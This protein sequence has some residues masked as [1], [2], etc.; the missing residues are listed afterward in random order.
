MPPTEAQ[1]ALPWGTADKENEEAQKA[2]GLSFEESIRKVVLAAA[3][4]LHDRGDV[5]PVKRA[6]TSPDGASNGEQQGA[7]LASSLVDPIV[8]QMGQA[9]PVDLAEQQRIEVKWQLNREN[10]EEAKW[11]GAT[12]VKAIEPA[13]AASDALRAAEQSTASD[14]VKPA[15]LWVMRYDAFE[16]FDEEEK[17]VAFITNHVLAH[18]D[19]VDEIMAWRNEGDEY[20]P[21]ELSDDSEDESESSR[22]VTTGADGSKTTAAELRHYGGSV[23]SAAMERMASVPAAAQ[24]HITEKLCEY[25]N[26]LAVTLKQL[27]ED[28]GT[29]GISGDDMREA[30]ARMK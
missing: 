23:E 28:K 24:Q 20:E 6:R 30:L 9:E 19:D 14:E 5:G 15:A 26:K 2:P 27:M 12:L 22:V 21:S 8:Y 16:G 25:S 11:W 29:G 4:D 17:E 1:P 7:A 13:A 10:S 18:T 3:V